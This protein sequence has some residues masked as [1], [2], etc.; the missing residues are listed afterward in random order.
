MTEALDAALSAL[1]PDARRLFWIITRAAPPVPETLVEKVWSGETVADEKLLQI[2][3]MMAALDRLPPE[4]RPQAPPMPDEV[5]SRVALL[6]SRDKPTVPETEPLV[7]ELIETRLCTRRPLTEDGLALAFA[8]EDA[9]AK[10]IGA[11]MDA[12]PEE[13]GERDEAAI[14][15]AYG[16]RYGAAFVA[17]VEGKVPGG[18]VEAGIEA[19]T[20]AAR[21]LLRAGA[22][23][24]LAAIVGEAVRAA[25]DAQI[26]GP[27]V[28][29]LMEQEALEACRE[30]LRK[31]RDALGE[32]GMLAALASFFDDAGERE[33]AI[34]Q[35][36]AALEALGGVEH[37]VAR[38]IVHLRLSGYLDREGRTEEAAAHHLSALL[39]RALSGSDF[40]NEVRALIERMGRAEAAYA[41]PRVKA[42]VGD[43]AFAD[44]ARF[45]EARGA[46][47]EDAQADV[48]ALVAQV[49]AHVGR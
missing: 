47:V 49:A 24:D 19:G 43:A 38:A 9:A 20:Q 5:R 15:R 14:L 41:L 40:S 44:L 17:A 42:L 27:V 29:F 2:S 7:G 8:F 32:A 33:V 28:F 13:R 3:R 35:A 22:F 45:V 10:A 46:A 23:D 25:E 1:S 6:Q 30:A 4:A 16:E 11:W 34:E 39:Y 18:T 37:P 26:V 21:I 48:D 31:R 36:R 12:H